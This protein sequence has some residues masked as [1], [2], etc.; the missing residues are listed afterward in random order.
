MVNVKICG[1]KEE[2]HVQSAVEAGATWIG[3]M[4]APSKRRISVKRAEDLAILVPLTLKE[5]EFL[6]IQQ[7]WKYVKR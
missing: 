2:I 1:L 6:L 7:N 3:F 4:F 5:L